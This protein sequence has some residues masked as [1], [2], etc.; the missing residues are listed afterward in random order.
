MKPPRRYLPGR[1]CLFCGARLTR[2][3]PAQYCYSHQSSP[4]GAA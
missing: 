3:N 1:A 4:F 2:Y